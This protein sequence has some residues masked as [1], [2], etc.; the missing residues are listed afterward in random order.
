MAV[1]KIRDAEGT[2][3]EV[4]AIKGEDYVLTEAD[5]QEIAQIVASMSPAVVSLDENRVLELIREN[6]PAS[7]EGVEY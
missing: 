3:Q 2:V 4:L 6:M 7:A 1:L 5:K